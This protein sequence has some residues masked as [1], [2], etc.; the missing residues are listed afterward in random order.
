MR[1]LLPAI[2]ALTLASPA[3]AQSW[4]EEISSYDRDRLADFSQS[5]SKGMAEAERGSSA[6]DLAIIHSV[7][8][9]EGAGVSEDAI[10]GAWRCRTIKLGGMTPSV[11]YSWFRCRIR[12]TRNGLY[13]EKVS[14][15]QRFY[16]YLD[17]YDNGG[18]VLLGSMGVG[19]ERPKPYS[20]ANRGAGAPATHTDSVGV[21]SRIGD[22]RLRIEFPNPF[23]ESTFDVME[24]KR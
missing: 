20:G 7:L 17:R 23:Y 18:F 22:G 2:L 6:G 19:R 15:T 11:V 8:D 13:F 10:Q 24:L 1:A 9:G 3:L 21:L 12:D 4:Q 5:K 14:G 16:G